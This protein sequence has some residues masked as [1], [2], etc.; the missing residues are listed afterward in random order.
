MGDIAIRAD[1]GPMQA[2]STAQVVAQVQ[3]I[4]DIMAKVMRD[5]EHYGKIPGTDKPTLLK[6]GAEKLGFTFRLIPRFD[7]K[8]TDHENGHRE[9]EV[10]CTLVGQGSGESVGQGVGTCSTMESKYRYR[11]MADYDVTDT[12]IP[13]DA[14]EHKAEYR[15]QGFGMKKVDGSW[16]WVKYKDSSRVE[17]PDIAD[18]YNTVLKMAKKRAHV[19]AVITATAA[20]DIFAQDLEETAEP[21]PVSRPAAQDRRPAIERIAEAIKAK[22]LSEDTRKVYREKIKHARTEADF[23]EILREV[24]DEGIDAQS[25][26][27]D[28]AAEA[29]WEEGKPA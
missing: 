22:G 4:Q 11:N 24:Q 17:N 28:A 1:A 6:A 14:K 20:S 23:E 21:A 2:L 9:Y 27:I 12:P 5:G 25:A 13:Q 8:R 7:V 19:D 16:Y 15:R 26:E 10:L 29:G 18:T 3:Q